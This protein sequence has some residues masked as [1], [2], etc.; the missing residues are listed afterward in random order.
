MHEDDTSHCLQQH[1]VKKDKLDLN[2]I[3]TVIN[4]SINPFHENIDKN[5]LF[6]ISTGKAA[7]QPIADF[8]LN[9][10]SIG[11]KQKMEFISECVK[12]PGR[13]VKPIRKNKILNF[14]SDC[15][16]KNK[17]VETEANAFY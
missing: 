9:I 5:S 10:T 6:N 15:I 2:R 17:E 16:K 1:Q 13:F 12:E 3:I 7:S 14:A 11:N 8:L 4:N